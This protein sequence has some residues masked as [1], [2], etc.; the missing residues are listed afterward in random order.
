MATKPNTKVKSVSHIDVIP[1]D[2][3]VLDH[4]QAPRH[5]APSLRRTRFIDDLVENWDDRLAGILTVNKRA[6]GTYAVLDGGHRLK[7]LRLRGATEHHASIYEGLTYEEEAAT[8]VALNVR[9]NALTVVQTMAGHADAGDEATVILERCITDAGFKATAS[10]ASA[11]GLVSM[12]FQLRNAVIDYGPAVVT[13]ALSWVNAAWPQEK[14]AVNIN[15]LM[16]AILFAAT[17]MRESAIGRSGGAPDK[18]WA[19]KPASWFL[20]A[21]R[22]RKAMGATSYIKSANG[23]K[24]KATLPEQVFVELREYYNQARHM[25]ATRLPDLDPAYPETPYLANARRS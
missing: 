15:M 16:G 14:A 4:Y 1:L 24:H 11:P 18:K 3:C 2:R 22:A 7:A 13:Q 8:F 5:M 10:S 9:R 12:T 6:D 19:Q 20:N 23:R 25:D 21:A 17:F